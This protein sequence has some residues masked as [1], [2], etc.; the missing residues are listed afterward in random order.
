[1]TNTEFKKRFLPL[2]KELYSMAMRMLG[3][4]C[5]AEDAVQNLYM[6][7]WERRDTLYDVKNDEAYSIRLLKNICIDRW[8]QMQLH[9][10]VSIDNNTDDTA[11]EPYN[12]DEFNDKQRFLRAFIGRLHERHRQIFIMKMRGCS[13]DEIEKLTGEPAVNLRMTVSRMKRELIN[14]YKQKTGNI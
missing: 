1:M 5:E 8:R 10:Q 14:S 6:K 4:S 9:Q 2:H 12:E 11:D 7:L 3:D 13:Y